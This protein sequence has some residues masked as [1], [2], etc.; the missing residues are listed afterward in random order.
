PEVLQLGQAAELGS[1]LGV[2]AIRRADGPRRAWVA[3]P[4]AQRVVAALAIDP[5][6]GVNGGQVDH[7]EAHGRDVGE[8]PL[9]ALEGRGLAQ[10]ATLRARKEL[11]PGTQARALAVDHERHLVVQA[12]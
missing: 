12:A 8:A 5:T 2:A 4:G 1:D 10:A 6:D 9:S 11:V 3:A 7:V